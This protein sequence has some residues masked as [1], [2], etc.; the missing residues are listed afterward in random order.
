MRNFK[1]SSKHPWLSL[2]VLLVMACV[3][4]PNLIAVP[5][6]PVPQEDLLALSGEIGRPGGRLVGDAICPDLAV[7]GQGEFG[8]VAASPVG[9]GIQ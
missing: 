6:S 1:A 3:A 2:S 5:Q 7:G 9:T 4:A 8:H